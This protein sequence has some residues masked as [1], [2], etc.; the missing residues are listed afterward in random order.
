MSATW[1][2]WAGTAEATATR[3]AAPRSVDELC[4]VVRSA[5][6]D[7]LRVKAVG[8]GHSFTDIAATDGLRIEMHHLDA[9]TAVRG[10][11][12]TVQ[13]GMPLR[14]LSEVL[15]GHGLA[16]ENLGDI[17]AQTISGAISTGTHG[18]GAGF[19]G[20][21]TQVRALELVLP[22]GSLVRCDATCRPEL[23]AAARVGLGAFGVIA[24]VTLECRPAFVLHA[25]ERPMPLDA[26]VEQ[27]ED[28][29]TGNDHFEF[30]WFP[31]TGR[32]LTKRN[33]QVTDD[34]LRPLNRVRAWV[35]D[36]LLSNTLYGA[37]QRVASTAP[38]LVPAVNAVSSRVLTARQYTDR[39]HRV[40][41]SDRRVVF[42]EME[43]A[44]PR[45]LV[46][47]VLRSLRDW[48]D[49][50]DEPVSFPVEVRFS[51]ADDIWLSTAQGRPT[52]YLAVH[53]YHR[54]PYQRWFE[55]VESVAT[56][57][58]GRPHW[59]KLHGLDAAALAELY[60]H[61]GEAVRVRDE[62]DPEGVFRNA[63]LDRVLGPA[64]G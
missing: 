64:G 31:H 17:D 14:R 3:V 6:R 24:T 61:H 9:V 59:G 30:F 48:V 35:D 45:D 55:A 62:V 5:A 22:D 51:A 25:D 46:V 57:V 53:Q 11:C 23:F 32:T 44:V 58:G 47:P 60:P 12:V 37:M 19:G 2:N 52:A 21:A 50:H 27:L 26:V 41:V 28:L 63:Y 34:R 1:R 20:L 54:L 36:D 18:T 42:R 49:S 39:S 56:S 13:G 40:F 43:Y 10:P 15:D 16:M 38:R 8:S 33:N 29:V 7:G 4:D